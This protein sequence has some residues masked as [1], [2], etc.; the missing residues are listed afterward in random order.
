MS[1]NLIKLTELAKVLNVDPVTIRRELKKPD[2]KI[3]VHIIGTAQRFLLSEVLKATE[4]NKDK[5]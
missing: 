5:N 3:P 4:H 2:S 1:E